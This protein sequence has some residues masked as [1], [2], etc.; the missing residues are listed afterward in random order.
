[1]NLKNVSILLVLGTCAAGLMFQNCAPGFQMSF[2]EESLKVTDTSTKRMGIDANAETFLIQSAG[3]NSSGIVLRNL[4]RFEREFQ[5]RY[6][7]KTEFSISDS[8]N[9]LA[10]HCL[11]SAAAIK[12][13]RGGAKFEDSYLSDLELTL[14]RSSAKLVSISSRWRAGWGEP[15]G[16]NQLVTRDLPNETAFSFD[17]G[18]PL[19][20]LAE[21]S[22]LIPNTPA[23]KS[24]GRSVASSWS[25][26]KGYKKTNS[27][28]EGCGYFWYA[29]HPKLN[30]LYVKNTSIIMAPGMLM[31]GQDANNNIIIDAGRG[32]MLSQTKE[33]DS[34]SNYYYWSVLEPGYQDTGRKWDPHN[35]LEAFS[36][37]YAGQIAQAKSSICTSIKHYET[38][39]KRG[40]EQL[41][42]DKLEAHK[43]RIR[44]SACHFARVSDEAEKSCDSQVL[45]G[46]ENLGAYIAMGLVMDYWPAKDYR[47]LCR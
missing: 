16:A 30:G 17:T 33:I 18:L 41:S 20:C 40:L 13:A 44:L 8:P 12:R 27:F 42:G 7:P 32:A 6:K 36:L 34:R 45:V 15:P 21:A 28:C 46:N 47:E 22:R 37:F 25:N 14:K 38:W 1:M 23:L 5:D 19:L 43:Y 10:S 4:D 26:E 11:A 3:Q 39:S 24:L 2:N 9:D 29:H 31:T 35:Y